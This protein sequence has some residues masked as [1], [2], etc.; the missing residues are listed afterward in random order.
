MGR[1]HQFQST[2]SLRRATFAGRYSSV[3]FP[4][5]STLSLRRATAS[6][7]SPPPSADISI[8]ALLAESDGN[9]EGPIRC[10]RRFQSTLSLRRATQGIQG[11]KGDTGISIHALLAESDTGTV[12]F[13]S[14]SHRIS[15]HALLAESDSQRTDGPGS[16]RNFN[17][18]SPCGERPAPPWILPLTPDFNPRSPCG[19]RQQRPTMPITVKTFQSTLSLRRATWQWH[20]CPGPLW[21]FNPR[22]PCGE[23]LA[24]TYTQVGNWTFQSTLSLRRA[25]FPGHPTW[26][27]RPISIHALL[28]E[29]DRRVPG[30]RPAHSEISIHALLAESDGTDISGYLAESDFNPRSPCGERRGQVGPVS[31]CC[32]ISIHALLAESDWC[33]W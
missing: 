24:G 20:D 13:F 6:T 30:G 33:E 26:S 4:F 17:P 27:T 5:Q 3:G 7:T 28:A 14:V 1:Q 19:E 16:G 25:T 29:S 9:G 8:H 11:D 22:S 18:R 12:C 32:W 23:R 2:L 31:G 10:R 21:D 15:I